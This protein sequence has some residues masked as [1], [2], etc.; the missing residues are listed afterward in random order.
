MLA[1]EQAAALEYAVDCALVITDDDPIT[2]EQH[3]DY[4]EYMNEVQGNWYDG[5][6]N[7]VHEEEYAPE[8]NPYE[9][10]Y[11]EDWQQGLDEAREWES[12]NDD[13]WDQQADEFLPG[14]F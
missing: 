12:D 3:K 10:E 13:Y 6:M 1:T 2:E 8:D 5:P 7:Y 4:V 9:D 11:W 14:Q